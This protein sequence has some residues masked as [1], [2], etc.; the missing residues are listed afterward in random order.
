MILA[1]FIVFILLSAPELSIKSMLNDYSEY[2]NSNYN[3]SM[4][5]PSNREI[6]VHEDSDINST[7]QKNL[8]L[9]NTSNIFEI[10][11]IPEQNISLFQYT[12][13]DINSYIDKYAANLFSSFSI[14]NFTND[15]NKFNVTSYCV[16]YFVIISSDKTHSPKSIMDCIVGDGSNNVKLK[17]HYIQ[18]GY[19]INPEN[20]QVIDSIVKSIAYR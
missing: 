19:K 6:Q 13:Y 3:L 12:M 14:Q 10:N 20:K 7:Y 4:I 2:Q 18:T 1:F 5:Y 16:E 8:S 11:F 17:L 9:D 15:I